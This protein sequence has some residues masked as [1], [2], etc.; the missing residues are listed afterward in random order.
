[1]R[2]IALTGA[3]LCELAS[4]LLCK[5]GSF[6]FKGRG[7][8]MYPFIRDGAVVTV[9]PVQPHCLRVGDVV[10]YRSED[11]LVVHR[12]VTKRTVDERVDLWIRGDVF[13]GPGEKLSSTSLLGRVVRVEQ[14]G[15]RSCL[16]NI[17]W[18]WSG[19]LW[20]RLTPIG[21]CFLRMASLIR[22]LSKNLSL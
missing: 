5:G 18:R 1:M 14:R 3:N 21:Q 2:E 7:W 9:D 15:K 11:S 8:S 20:L 19:I 22:R 17:F 4:E 6:Q 16:N 10:L 13:S 12:I